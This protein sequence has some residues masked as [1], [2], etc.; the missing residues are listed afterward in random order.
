MRRKSFEELIKAKFAEGEVKT[1]DAIWRE[2]NTALN[3]EAV[4]NYRTSLTRYK[5]VAAASILIAVLSFAANFDFPRKNTDKISSNYN[6]LMP[7]S[8]GHFRFFE[9]STSVHPPSYQSMIPGGMPFTYIDSNYFSGRTTTS[10]TPQKLTEYFEQTPI[11]IQPLNKII[12]EIQTALVPE[13]KIDEYRMPQNKIAL[14]RDNTKGRF[15][16]SIEAGHGNFDLEFKG[17]EPIYA[18]PNFETIASSLEKD[19]FI[20]PSS[21]ITQSGMNEGT[22]RSFGMDFGV[23][24]GGK[25]TLESG[26]QFASISSS[27]MASVSITDVYSID[28]PLLEGTKKSS[29][30]ARIHVKENIERQVN[31]DNTTTFTTVPI[32]AGYFLVDKKLSLRLNAGLNANYFL[33]NRIDDPSGQFQSSNKRSSYAA[34]SF[35]GLGGLELGYNV[36]S[37]L[38]FTLEPNY[39]QSITPLSSNLTGRSGLLIHTGLRYYIR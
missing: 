37:H 34:W 35:D 3:R 8:P 7:S 29:I 4:K 11:A 32:K 14:A 5:W 10:G 21:T 36:I 38:N 28:N 24:V 12:P 13:E 20:N 30:A 27:G 39:I 16:A 33:D 9:P 19:D 15:W 17:A 23:K 18:Q 26:M 25:W 22:L 1:T 31:F 6:A 2:I